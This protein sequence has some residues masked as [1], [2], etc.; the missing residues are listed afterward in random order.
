LLRQELGG[1]SGPL[2]A[3][4]FLR[5]G[6]ALETAGAVGLPQWVQA[7]DQGCQAISQLGGAKP[8]DRTMLDALDPFVKQLQQSVSVTITPE[9]LLAAVEVAERGAEATAQ[10][11]P[12]LGRSS[13]LGD[14]V[15]GHPDPGAKAIAIWLR[16]VCGTL[17]PMQE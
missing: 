8:G 3:V 5:C 4:F 16:A 7:L 9:L 17:F 6:S 14:R 11:K 13:Y 10:M 1:S 12:R 15:L 2:Y